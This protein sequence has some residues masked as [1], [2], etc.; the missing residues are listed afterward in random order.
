MY[1][2]SRSRRSRRMTRE[3][4]PPSLDF[5]PNTHLEARALVTVTLFNAAGLPFGGVGANTDGT[6]QPADG[7]A[8][9]PPA[10]SADFDPGGAASTASTRTNT[11]ITTLNF[12]TRTPTVVDSVQLTEAAIASSSVTGPPPVAGGNSVTATISTILMTTDSVTADSNGPFAI[13]NP[14]AYHAVAGAG[15][16]LYSWTPSDLVGGVQYAPPVGSTATVSFTVTLTPPTARFFTIPTI[17]FESTHLT[18]ALTPA[19]GLVV[20]DP[21]TTPP[22]LI[23]RDL[24]FAAGGFYTTGPITDPLAGTETVT[25]ASALGSGPAGTFNNETAVQNSQLSWSFSLAVA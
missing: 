22:T 13:G 11:I 17:N 4:T 6:A 24:A 19:G 18:V 10:L 23:H 5:A 8:G 20:T 16:T 15:S 9:D 3:F 12:D 25:Y 1:G 7:V 14:V 2:T 21:S